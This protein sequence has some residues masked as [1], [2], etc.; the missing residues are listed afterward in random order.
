MTDSLYDNYPCSAEEE[1][2]YVRDSNEEEERGAGTFKKFNS[3]YKNALDN[4]QMAGHSGN[5]QKMLF[6]NI[7]ITLFVPI[8]SNLI[9]PNFMLND[10][11]DDN[12]EQL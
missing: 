7:N 1:N 8:D 10:Y 9:N 2:N 12:F 11:L 6:T 3:V 5:E 4:N